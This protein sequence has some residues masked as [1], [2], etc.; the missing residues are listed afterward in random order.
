MTANDTTKDAES[1]LADVYRHMPVEQ[2]WRRL[3]DLYRTARLLHEAG[4]RLRDPAATD[5]E[6]VQD[7]LSVTLEPEL[8]QRV[9][10]SIP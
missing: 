1:V 10:E 2:K 7:W 8:L 4:F 3:G 6:V 9:R 5:R